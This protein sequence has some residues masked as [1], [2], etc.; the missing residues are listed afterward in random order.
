MERDERRQFQRLKLA[1]PILATMDSSNALVLD[2]GLGGALLEHYGAVVV[3]DEFRL[4]FRWQG[5]DIQMLCEAVR[6]IVVRERGGDGESIVSHTG[7]RFVDAAGH[8]EARLQDLVSKFVSRIV[9][10][11]KANA[12]GQLGE[13][14]GES[15]LARMGEAHRMRSRGYLAC[16]LVEGTWTKTPTHSSEQP[17]DGF[18][19]G[20]Y[21]DEDEVEQLCRTYEAADEEGR[22]LIRHVCENTLTAGKE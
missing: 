4:T 16:H 9:A 15:I 12:S 22:N 17:A 5:Q 3:G 20:D 19:V 8:S 14:A 13:S 6:T 21:E 7:V 10:A 2:I 1:K 18:I 11:Q